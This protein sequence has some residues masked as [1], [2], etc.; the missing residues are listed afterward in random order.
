[1]KKQL[2]NYKNSIVNLAIS[3]LKEFGINENKP[4]LSLMDRYFQKGYEN[5]IILLLDGMGTKVIE[6]NLDKSGFFNS[7]Y[8]ATYS[9][10]F[11]PTTVASTTSIL[12][13][14]NPNE[15]CWLGWDCYFPQIDKN[16]SVFTNKETGTDNVDAADFNVAQKFCGYQSIISKINESG[17][18]A[19][20]VSKFEE[21]YPDT[22]TKICEEIDRLSQKFGKK[23]IYAYW[24]EPD[25]TM[26]E[27][28]CNGEKAK[29]VCRE[30][31]EKVKNLCDKIENALIVV[32]ADHG[33]INSKGVLIS[34]Y[35]RIYECLER[36]PSIEPRA[37]NFFV[38]KEKIK[39]FE[40]DFVKEFG[41]KFILLNHEQVINEKLFGDGDDNPN[42][43]DMIGDFLAVAIGDLSIYSSKWEVD[44]FKGVH[45][46][47]T[48]DEMN[49]PL[50]VIEKK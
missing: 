39:Q 42:F 49:I 28:G 17:G 46:G 45:A 25:H 38:K 26:H 47:L 30:L 34:D 7:H 31:E 16:V 10:V 40:F 48:S 19:F 14:M 9:S 23:Y 27:D 6:E 41:E 22:F 33:H 15:H 44:F 21:P 1:M 11:P 43:N 18:Q 24:S 37:V 2:P 36:L 29:K 13:G 35:P 32:T 3:V 20:T 8:I 4:S 50:I 5:I 12:S